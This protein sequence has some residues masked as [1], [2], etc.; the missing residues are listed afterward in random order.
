MLRRVFMLAPLLTIPVLVY[1]LV[2][3]GA[4]DDAAA[5]LGTTLFSLPMIS[6][7]VWAFS[8][9]DA[10]LALALGFLFIEIVKATNT[11]SASLANHGLSTG[12]LV[13]CVIEF[14]LLRSF[15][16]SV[17]FLIL[18]MTALDVLAG[19]MVTIVS[20]RRDFGVG[21]GLTG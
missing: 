11:K 5:R 16:T 9:G 13:F 7:G 20:A 15:A 6:G 2:V 8:L 1:H 17:F 10:L 3:L 21:D 19:F 12:L 18:L 4:G 14:L